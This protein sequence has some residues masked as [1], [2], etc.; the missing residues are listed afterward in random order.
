MNANTATHQS[1][2]DLAKVG[3]NKD[4]LL[5]ALQGLT[6]PQI[7]SNLSLGKGTVQAVVIKANQ[8]VGNL[9]N[10]MSIKALSESLQQFRKTA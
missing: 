5:L 10:E 1:L 6:I 7:A 2:S 9:E 3:N 8:I 4:I